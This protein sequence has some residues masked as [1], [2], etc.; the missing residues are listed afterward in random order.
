MDWDSS[1]DVAIRYGLAGQGPEIPVGARFSSPI[2]TD[3]AD[4]TASYAMGTCSFPGVKR[5][6][7]GADHPPPSSSEVKE[8]V[9]LYIYSPPPLDLRGLF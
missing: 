9:K 2:Q 6:G 3:P 5:P 8:R 4:Y 7:R 1:V